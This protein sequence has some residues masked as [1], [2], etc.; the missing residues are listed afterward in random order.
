MN[1]K[2]SLG[3][4][5]GTSNSCLA[6]CPVDGGAAHGIDVTQILAPGVVGERHLLPSALYIPAPGEY[7]PGSLDL[8]WHGAADA[9]AVI[10]TF[11]PRARCA[12]AGPAGVVGQVL[13]V[14]S[15]RRPPCADPALAV[16]PDAKA[17]S[18]PSRHRAAIWNTCA[19]PPNITWRAH[20]PGAT[21]D[22]CQVVLTVPASFD[23]VA[24]SLTHEARDSG[25]PRQRQPAGRAAGG[26]LRLDRPFR[27]G[28]GGGALDRAG[29]AGD[30]ML[31][32]DVGGGTADFSLIAVAES[33]T[34]GLI[35]AA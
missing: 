24:R 31:V 32:C 23:E 7:A 10:G 17:R 15:A 2:Y 35:E 34:G 26:V 4:D 19:T 14:Q 12:G 20:E 11:R 27:G 18:R 13:A 21:L 5:L 1:K 28:T 3:I 6:L 33:V 16:G 8:P 30:L 25:R 29:G 22:D 9:N